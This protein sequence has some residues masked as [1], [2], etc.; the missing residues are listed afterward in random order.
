[1][2][3]SLLSKARVLVVDDEPSNLRLLERIL[4]FFQ[5]GAVRTLTDP[6]EAVPTVIE[7]QPD[8]LLLDLNMPHLD[9]YRV[10]ELLAE[11]IP[12][13]ERQ[14]VIVMTADITTEAKRRALGAGAKDFVTKPFDQTEIA[15]RMK[16]L[17]ENRFLHLELRQQ[18]GVLEDLV[19]ERTQQLEDALEDLRAAQDG[20]VKQERLSAL[21]MMAG[22]IAH[23][24]NNA[25]TMVLGYAD[26]LCP[27]IKTQG[28]ARELSFVEHIIAAAQDATHIVG[29]LREFYRPV[30]TDEVREPLDLNAIVEQ[31]VAL[32]APKWKA[33]SQAAGIDI[34]V[35]TELR[36]TPRI[37]G[38]AAELR[39]VLTNLIFNAVDAMPRGG[40]IVI[41]TGVQEDGRVALTVTDTGTGM[42]EEQRE[43]CLEPFFTT[44]GDRGTGLG[45]SVVYGILQRHE[46]RLEIASQL[47]QG[48]TFNITFAPTEVVATVGALTMEKV[49]RPLQIL[50]VDDQELICELIAECLKSD[51]HKTQTAANGREALELFRKTP[52]DLVIT[53]QSMPGMN[54]VQLSVS[55]KQ[56]APNT[57]V[58]LLTGFGEELNAAGHAPGGVNLV[59]G[60]PVSAADLRRA[61]HQVVSAGTVA[62]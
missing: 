14:P 26:L 5:A 44:K 28:A 43:R 4:E 35:L 61:I 52:A 16:N 58:I 17:L 55:I 48:T 23:D 60:K 3:T 42:T 1:M 36:P 51:G 41:T 39:E 29:R 49:E 15:L 18:N 50:V 34:S 24:F 13:E 22:G 11:A 7:W 56:Q 62:S 10:L 19:Q 37:A 33:T 31:A 12:A 32:T 57:P 54:G 59:V 25:L 40:S 27:W 30:A 21:G 46:G 2:P 6:R 8:I 47:R 53:D 45:L 38:C 9:G 20:V